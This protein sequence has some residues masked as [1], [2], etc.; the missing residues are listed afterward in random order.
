MPL[1]PNDTPT[2]RPRLMRVATPL[3]PPLNVEAS[4]TLTA[5]KEGGTN[6]PDVDDVAACSPSIDAAPVEPDCQGTD[7]PMPSAG[8]DDHHDDCNDG[9]HNSTPRLSVVLAPGEAQAQAVS[10]VE[11][12]LGQM[13]RH[14]FTDNLHPSD[15]RQS[16][17]ASVMAVLPETVYTVTLGEHLLVTGHPNLMRLLAPWMELH[18]TVG[19]DLP[20]LGDGL[21][22]KVTLEG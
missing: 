10:Y 8:L 16:D 6:T 20:G 14:A 1:D 2:P 5:P 7:A 15:S 21:S 12:M 17:R 3:A 4:P 11:L 13:V 22:V 19:E 9:A 18:R